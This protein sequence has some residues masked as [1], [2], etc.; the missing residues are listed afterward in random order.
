MHCTDLDPD[1]ARKA[2]EYLTRAGVYGRVTYHT[3]SA[4]RALE[5][6]GGTWDVIY[7]DIDK[8]GYPDTVDLAYRHLRPGG[9]FITDNVLWQGRVLE[10]PD[11]DSTRGVVE[12]TRRLCWPTPAS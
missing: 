5:K 3:D 6:V 10:E 4:T 7:N 11:G 12:F 1:N 9:L 2:E 8:E